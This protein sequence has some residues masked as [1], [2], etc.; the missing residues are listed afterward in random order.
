MIH[1]GVATSRIKKNDLKTGLQQC[2]VYGGGGRTRMT[3][4][5]EVRLE[6][7]CYGERSMPT[8]ASKAGQPENMLTGSKS[9][10][11]SVFLTTTAQSILQRTRTLTCDLKGMLTGRFKGR[12]VETRGGRKQGRKKGERNKCQK[13]TLPPPKEKGK[14]EKHLFEPENHCYH[15]DVCRR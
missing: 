15:A 12:A 10:A 1:S 2:G 6:G 7:F 14:G 11:A 5:G 8:V 9:G 4:S 13:K 3:T